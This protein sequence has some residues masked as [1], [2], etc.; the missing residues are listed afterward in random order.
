MTAKRA[1][2]TLN[3][4]LYK[5]YQWIIKKAVNKTIKHSHLAVVF[6]APYV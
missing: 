5:V 1:C 3:E 2:L 4:K 6:E